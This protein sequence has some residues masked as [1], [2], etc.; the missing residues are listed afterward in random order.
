MNAALETLLHSPLLP[1]Y[2]ERIQAK[3]R[4]EAQR[5]AKFYDEITEE[6]KWEFIEGQV[7]MHSPAKNRHLCAVMNITTL[8]NHYV[9]INQLGAVRTEKCMCRFQRND[10]EPDV[11]FFG[12]EKAAQFDSLTMLFP[13]PDLVVEVLSDSTAERDRGVKFEDYERHVPEYWI[14]DAQTEVVEQYV[15]R[16]SG[17]LLKMKAGNG[18]LLSEAITGFVL[19]VRA[20]FDEVENLAALKQITASPL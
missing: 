15:K 3:L 18:N 9:R 1:E 5:R 7:I 19:P 4:D 17:Y 14:V 13:P 6:H 16:E 2:A 11:V 12:T 20:V 8:M 10:Y